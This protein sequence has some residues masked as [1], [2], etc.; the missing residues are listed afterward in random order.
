MA[1]SRRSGSCVLSYHYF[2]LGIRNKWTEDL[3]VWATSDN[4]EYN[5]IKLEC[6]TD[7]LVRV[8]LC[9]YIDTYHTATRSRR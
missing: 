6:D 5:R 9:D 4:T 2:L 1:S 7:K 3:T 8:P